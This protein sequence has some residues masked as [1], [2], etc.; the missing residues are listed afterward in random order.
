MVKFFTFLRQ[1]F[2]MRKGF[3]FVLFLL[4]FIP[5][6]HAQMLSVKLNIQGVEN[7]IYIP[8]VGERL[9]SSISEEVYTTP[10]HFYILSYSG[11]S[12]NGLVARDGLRVYATNNETFHSI[13][14]DQ[15]LDN[16]RIFLVFSKGNW[17][18]VE[19]K[20]D[21]IESGKFLAAISPSFAF[22]LGTLY[23]IRLILTYTGIDLIGNFILGM[24]QHKIVVE[25]LGTSDGK[26]LV[27]ITRI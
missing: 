1:L 26:T 14:I 11:T 15:N 10:Q 20:I 17:R 9:A 18:T 3:M 16:S 4:V 5:S 8:G 13:G 24:G 6:V 22:G 7:A 2:N 23:P 12:L 27:K 21:L 25:N 19:S